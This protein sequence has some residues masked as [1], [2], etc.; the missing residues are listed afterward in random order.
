MLT[1]IYIYTCLHVICS[2]S[3]KLEQGFQSVVELHFGRKHGNEIQSRH[4]RERKSWKEILKV[5]LDLESKC[6]GVGDQLRPV[7]RVESGSL[8]NEASLLEDDQ[9]KLAGLMESYVSGTEDEDEHKTAA[10]NFPAEPV[11]A[12][13]VKHVVDNIYIYT[14][15]NANINIYVYT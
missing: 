14:Q 12:L 3:R 7:R 8:T 2:R 15:N 4:L 10:G 9:L 6:L 13:Q 1:Y 11:K 5:T